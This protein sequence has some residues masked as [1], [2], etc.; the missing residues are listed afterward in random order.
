MRALRR[1]SLASHRRP[2]SQERRVLGQ[3]GRN[4]EVKDYDE[5]K[6]Q[7]LACNKGPNLK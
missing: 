4:V 3:G 5:I 7:L 6:Q 2:R 1:P